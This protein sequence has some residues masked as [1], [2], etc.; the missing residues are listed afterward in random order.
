MEIQITSPRREPTSGSRL[1]FTYKRRKFFQK[2]PWTDAYTQSGSSPQSSTRNPPPRPWLSSVPMGLSGVATCPGPQRSTAA[3]VATTSAGCV[4]PVVFDAIFQTECLCR[5]ELRMKLCRSS[6]AKNSSSPSRAPKTG[7]QLQTTWR[8][9][10][11]GIKKTEKTLH[12]RHN[13]HCWK[14]HSSHC[15]YPSLLHNRNVSRRHDELNLR[16]LCCWRDPNLSLHD[17]RDV[18][19]RKTAP[20]APSRTCTTGTSS[21]LSSTTTGEPNTTT[22]TTVSLRDNNGHVNNLVQ[23][24]HDAAAP[25]PAPSGNPLWGSPAPPGL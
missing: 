16:H 14:L 5:Q 12:R 21:T 19:N 8:S 23:E 13:R 15:A 25:T 22:C 9:A 1:I 20:A 6:M 11:K 10:K 2:H 4:V 17:R 7:A 3:R 18:H 24:R